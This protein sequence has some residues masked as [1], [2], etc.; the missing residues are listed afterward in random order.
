MIGFYFIRVVQIKERNT[1]SVHEKRKDSYRYYPVEQSSGSEEHKLFRNSQKSPESLRLSKTAKGWILLSE[2]EGAGCHTNVWTTPSTVLRRQTTWPLHG[3]GLGL[4][5]WRFWA[6][7]GVP[8]KLLPQ[9]FF[10]RPVVSPPSSHYQEKLSRNLE[11]RLIDGQ[12]VL[13]T[14]YGAKAHLR[15]I[16]G[17]AILPT[18]C[19]LLLKIPRRGELTY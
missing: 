8:M 15:V 16:W 9:S 4:L 13:S 11:I 17:I 2:V 1:F 3:L 7:S 5:Q 14:S 6:L 19:L 18:R 12:H 10:S